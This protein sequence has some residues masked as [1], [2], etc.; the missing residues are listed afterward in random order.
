MSGNE[1]A[2]V[3]ARKAAKDGS[4]QTS[5]LPVFLSGGPLLCSVTAAHQHFRLDMQDLWKAKWAMSPQH[6]RLAPIDDHLPSIAFY[7]DTAGFTRAQT[8]LITQLCMAHIPLNKHLYRIKRTPTPICPACT[9]AKESIHHYLFDC[10]AHEH[11]RI[12]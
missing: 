7:R 3:E 5:E 12:A 10:R 9:R 8:S 2:D 4:S 1:E 6:T 11:A